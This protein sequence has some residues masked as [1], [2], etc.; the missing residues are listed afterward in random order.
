MGVAGHV[1]REEDMRNAYKMY[2]RKFEGNRPPKISSE[3]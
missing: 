2:V 1:A 3:T